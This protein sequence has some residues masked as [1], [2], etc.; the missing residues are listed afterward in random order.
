[1]KNRW[2]TF[3]TWGAE[4]IKGEQPKN[5]PFIKMPENPPYNI[6]MHYWKLEKG[7]IIEM[8]KEEKKLSELACKNEASINKE[9]NNE[10]KFNI[11]HKRFNVLDEAFKNNT[12]EID[13]IYDNQTI[14]A[15]KFQ[16]LENRITKYT[17]D[18]L[19]LKKHLL[20][21]E[22]DID[23]LEISTTLESEQ[24]TKELKDHQAFVH[25]SILEFDNLNQQ[26]TDELED[27][28]KKDLLLIHEKYSIPKTE[29]FKYRFKIKEYMQI[30]GL[31]GIL[32]CILHM[33]IK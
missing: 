7:E 19:A 14:I 2:I 8:S 22:E 24:L 12:E 25:N 11:I 3:H 27:R 10:E 17:E 18:L 1:M 28:I 15:H 33:L 16:T 5:I 29:N 6:P 32:Y 30:I 9:N 13:I 23:N 20:S 31:S 21:L 4:I 26:A